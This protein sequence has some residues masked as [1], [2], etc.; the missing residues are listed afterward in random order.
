MNTAR[1]EEMNVQVKLNELGDQEGLM[2]FYTYKIYRPALCQT[3][4]YF[5]V[6]KQQSVL[7]DHKH[8]DEFNMAG[9]ERGEPQIGSTW[10]QE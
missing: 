4:I 8:W 2:I 10:V 9:S 1:N 5:H 7:G 6:N 3:A